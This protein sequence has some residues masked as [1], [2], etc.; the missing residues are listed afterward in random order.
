MEKLDRLEQI[1]LKLRKWFPATKDMTEKQLKKEI[2]SNKNMQLIMLMMSLVFASFLVFIPD[3]LGVYDRMAFLGVIV[4]GIALEFAFYT[5][6]RCAELEAS[7]ELRLR[8]ALA[9]AKP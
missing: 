8:E 2:K 9:N 3:S 5:Q 6:H 7:F 4:G 1:R